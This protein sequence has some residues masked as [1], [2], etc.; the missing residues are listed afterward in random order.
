MMS[1]TKVGFLSIDYLKYGFG[2]TA[3]KGKFLYKSETHKKNE[4]Y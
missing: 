2:A 3:R 1:I 4:K